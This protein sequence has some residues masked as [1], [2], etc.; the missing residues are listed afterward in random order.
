MKEILKELG[1]KAAAAQNSGVMYDHDIFAIPRFPM[2]GPF[3]KIAAFK[4][5]A[6]MHALRILIKTAESSLFHDQQNPP[7]ISIVFDSTGADLARYNCYIGEG[8]ISSIN[9]NTVTL[10]AESKLKNRRTLYKIT[11]PGE[12]ANE[13]YWYSHLWVQPEISE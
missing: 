10:Q 7:A 1:F 5:K 4:E 6:N 3:T 11:A 12:S 2:A 13:W 9:D 8:C